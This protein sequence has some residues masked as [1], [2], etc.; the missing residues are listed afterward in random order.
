[1]KHYVFPTVE[2]ILI[3][4]ADVLTASL[5]VGDQNGEIPNLDYNEFL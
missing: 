5:N 3:T 2:L 4:N 1:M